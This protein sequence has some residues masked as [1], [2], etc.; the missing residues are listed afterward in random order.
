ML[1]S[2]VEIKALKRAE[3]WLHPVPAAQGISDQPEAYSDLKP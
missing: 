3:L 2:S 1:N